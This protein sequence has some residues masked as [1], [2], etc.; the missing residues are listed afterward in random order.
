ML[1]S[2]YALADAVMFTFLVD[3]RVVRENVYSVRVAPQGKIRM[4]PKRDT[5]L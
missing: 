1:K 5:N 2:L 4:S 3:G